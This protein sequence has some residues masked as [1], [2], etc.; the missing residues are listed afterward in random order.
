MCFFIE[1]S[2]SV[3]AA[4]QTYDQYCWKIYLH[5]GRKYS[6]PQWV[7]KWPK[8]NLINYNW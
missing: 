2:S 4:I 7:G 1:L 6:R 8:I 5:C 3:H